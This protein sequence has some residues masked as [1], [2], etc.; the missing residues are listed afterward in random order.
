MKKKVLIPI[1]LMVVAVMTLSFTADHSIK[2]RL[3][4]K[5]GKVYVI[6][7][8]S[9][10][11]TVMKVQGQTVRSTQSVDVRQTFK[12]TDNTTT[13]NV[14]ETKI[15]TI[16]MSVSAMGMNLT[17]DSDHPENTS[18]ILADQIGEIDKILNKPTTLTYNKLGQN[19]NPNDL[20]MSQ[21]SNVIIELPE[22]EV[23][24]GS[25]WSYVKS[26]NISNYDVSVNMTYTVTGISKKSVD[27]SFTGAINTKDMSGT[28][29]GTA[30]INPQTGVVMSGTI[31]NDISAT[32]T[33]QGFVIP[34]TITGT[35]TISVK[36]Q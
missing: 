32:I 9:T 3:N 6:N 27:V 31:S 20:D 22:E 35:T 28:Y 24:V 4:P 14:F 29:S 23:H 33:E 11:T 5:Q 17:Y 1:F 16:K 13:K 19:S 2:L 26:Q 8:K 30:S 7:S 12:V 10:Q 15:E 25:Q 21:L 18:P 36:E 34:T